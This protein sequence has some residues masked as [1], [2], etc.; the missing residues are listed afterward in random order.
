VPRLN[1]EWEYMFYLDLELNPDHDIGQIRD[2]L[3]NYTTN[4]EVLGI[5]DKGE[6]LYE[7]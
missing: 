1:G 6:K 7:S 5:Y 3:E 2:V 4:L